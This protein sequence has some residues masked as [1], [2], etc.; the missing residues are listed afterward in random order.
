MP[1]RKLPGPTAHHAPRTIPCEPGRAI[2]RRAL[3]IGVPTVLHPFV[4]VAVDPI[5]SPGIRCEG[6]HCHGSLSVLSLASATICEAPIIIGLFGGD[7]GSPPER[8]RRT[9]AGHVF[10]FRLAEQPIRPTGF[11]RNPPRV[12]SGV[13][14]PEIDNGQA[15]APPAT[16]RRAIVLAAAG[17]DAGIPFRERYRKLTHGK[18]VFKHYPMLW[19]L[20]RV[21]VAF[22]LRRAHGELTR[23]HHD[24]SG[25]ALA[26]L[27]QV[28]G[29]QRSLLRS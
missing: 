1:R 7:R 15:A 27:E 22:R 6:F 14:P 9:G 21:A 11:F 2:G 4:D 18:S 24:H 29:L 12:S 3:V 28:L 13:L 19:P 26:F 25:A 10:S 16:I 5:E 20:I 23:R 8:S 17:G